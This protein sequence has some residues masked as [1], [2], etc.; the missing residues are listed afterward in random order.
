L[1]VYYNRYTITEGR[2]A[3]DVSPLPVPPPS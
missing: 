2:R 1:I 3:E